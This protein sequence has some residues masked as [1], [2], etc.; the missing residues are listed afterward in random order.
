[1]DEREAERATWF[2]KILIYV[3][4]TWPWVIVGLVALV[5]YPD[6]LEQGADPEI[7]YLRLMMDYLPAGLLGLVVASLVAA[8]MSTVSTE[9]NWGARYLTRA[10]HRRLLCSGSPQ[11]ASG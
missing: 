7:G 11:R 6:L 9:I 1:K 10:L 2:F 3:V 8:F 4:R 5:L